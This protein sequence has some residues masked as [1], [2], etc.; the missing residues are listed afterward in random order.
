VGIVTTAVAL[1][2]PTSIDPNSVEAL[3]SRLN[4]L[5]GGYSPP[6]MEVSNL[7]LLQRQMIFFNGGIGLT[8]VGAVFMA[9]GSVLGTLRSR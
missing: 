2:L 7:S 1:V 3:T 4:A 9:A 6:A 5:T 8:V